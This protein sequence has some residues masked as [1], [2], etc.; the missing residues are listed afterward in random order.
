MNDDNYENCLQQCERCARRFDD[1]VLQRGVQLISCWYACG[2]ENAL[3]PRV[4]SGIEG[5]ATWQPNYDTLIDTEMSC[6]TNI[7]NRLLYVCFILTLMLLEHKKDAYCASCYFKEVHKAR[8]N[9]YIVVTR[10]NLATF[11]CPS[12]FHYGAT[13]KNNHANAQLTEDLIVSRHHM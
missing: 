11:I 2:D 4:E 10:Y 5:L 8:Y 13:N 1:D 12:P 7:S 6:V 3:L 9:L